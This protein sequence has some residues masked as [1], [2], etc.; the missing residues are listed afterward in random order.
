MPTARVQSTLRERARY[1]RAKPTSHMTGKMQ[2]LEIVLN[3]DR[4]PGCTERLAMTRAWGERYRA[5]ATAYMRKRAY[6]FKRL[7]YATQ[8]KFC[9]E[10]THE[11]P[12]RLLY[13]TSRIMYHQ[14]IEDWNA[15]NYFYEDGM[16]CPPASLAKYWE[17]DALDIVK[18]HDRVKAEASIVTLQLQNEYDGFDM[19]TNLD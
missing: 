17:R 11:Y 9:M 3:N 16:D 8:I 18:F 6:H 12:W 13:M 5:E 14:F 19:D 4:D 15:T 1:A 10:L 2:A 7:F